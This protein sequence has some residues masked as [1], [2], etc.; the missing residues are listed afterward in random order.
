[1]NKTEVVRSYNFKHNINGSKLYTIEKII[2]PEWKRIAKILLDKHIHDFKYNFKVNE[3]NK[4]YQPIQT[5][6]SERYKD[7]INRQVVGMIKSKLSNFKT[8]FKEIVLNCDSF[9][10]ETKKKLCFIN[11]YNMYFY[12][13]EYSSNKIQ[14]SDELFRLAKWIFRNFIGKLP[15]PKYINMV[16]QEKIAKLEDS[17]NIDSEKYPY[18]IRLSTNIKGKLISLPLY[19][20]SYFDKFK[21]KLKTSTEFVFSDGKLEYIKLTKTISSDEVSDMKPI[22]GNSLTIDIGLNNLITTNY[23][24]LL[25]VK[26]LIKLKK[27]DLRINNLVKELKLKHG[28]HVKLKQFDEYNK[29][30]SRLSDYT[31]NE[32]NRIINKLYLKYRFKT[33][34]LEKLDFKNSNLSKTLNRLLHRFGLGA[35]NNKLK[36]LEYYGVK[37]NYI[38]SAYSSQTCNNCGYVDKNN[39]QKQEEFNCRCCG[40]KQHADVNAARTLD[41]FSKRFGDKIFYGKIG[42]ENKLKLIINDF[43]DNQFWMNN[44]SVIQV[45]NKNKY[46][47]SPQDE[48]KSNV[49]LT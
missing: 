18:I 33:I 7:A 43:K 23:G 30:I 21:G 3:K 2:Y 15:N 45:I 41:K 34:N 40:L 39:R 22:D 42:R 26:Y 11:K 5:I 13:G 46:F 16:M 48:I 24:E 19:R 17:T 28:K 31:K 8:R 10:E 47:K 32:V 35:I 38:D 4:I 29:L 25:G 6:L 27:F 9:D 20:N 36:S 14:I 49:H 12:K 1:M 44:L 37:V